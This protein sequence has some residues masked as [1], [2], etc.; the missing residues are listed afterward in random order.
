[1]K[2]MKS[3]RPRHNQRLR[4]V[5]RRDHMLRVQAH[6]LVGGAPPHGEKLVRGTSPRDLVLLL[7]RN[8]I[9]PPHEIE[10]WEYAVK[11][12]ITRSLRPRAQTSRS[13]S[14]RSRWC[15]LPCGTRSS[16]SS[17]TT[18]PTRSPSP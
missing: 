13:S 1:M 5:R 3:G 2:K 8:V 10:K 14:P 4:E 11:P 12:A 9:S 6:G 18:P 17:P 7:S 15:G 16:P